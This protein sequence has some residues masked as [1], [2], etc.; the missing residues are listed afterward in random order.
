MS[1]DPTNPAT[2]VQSKVMGNMESPENPPKT[3]LTTGL[4]GKIQVMNAKTLRNCA[5]KPGIK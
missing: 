1:G 3:W 5:R 4:F 2:C